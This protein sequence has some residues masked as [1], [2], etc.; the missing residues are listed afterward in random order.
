MTNYRKL[1]RWAAALVLVGAVLFG[2]LY[3]VK[4]EEKWGNF[5]A[6]AKG[7]APIVQV[8]TERDFGW[9]TGDVVPLTIYV[10]SF[11]G[12]QVDVDGLALEGD[13]EIR[14]DIKVDSRSTADGG[15]ITRIRMD[16]QSFAFKPVVSARISMTWNQ[17]G[18]RDWNEV[19]KSTVELHTSP[20]WDGRQQLQEGHPAFIQG[21]HLVKMLAMF[22]LGI[23]GVILATLYIRR[24]IRNMPVVVE[25]P[26]PLTLYDWAMMR[27]DRVWKRVEA[28]DRTD[29][30]FQEIDYITRTL[31][32]VQTVKISHIDIALSDH[33]F[34]KQGVYIIKTCERVL[35][36]GDAI[37][38]KHV[39]ALKTAFDEIVSRKVP[40][41]LRLPK[42]GSVPVAPPA[43]AQPKPEDEE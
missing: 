40:S 29:E 32:H 8:Q 33:P 6:D 38:D 24:E 9:R 37:S 17:E 11:P 20:T 18:S 28:G 13:F 19:P 43:V 15:K 2:A 16:V 5:P 31:M 35:F 1:F 7:P 10:K 26:Q 36:R 27:F 3:F 39:R 41:L 25:P 42:P 4:T 21:M 23:G 34:K 30:V 22:A 14:G 12:T